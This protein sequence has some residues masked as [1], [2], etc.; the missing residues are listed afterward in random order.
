MP[1]TLAAKRHP[2]QEQGP[3]GIPCQRL[4]PP[5]SRQT[6]RKLKEHSDAF[7]AVL[8]PLHERGGRPLLAPGKAPAQGSSGAL[9]PL[10]GQFEPG[11]AAASQGLH[12]PVR[13]SP[14]DLDKRRTQSF[15][16]PRQVVSPGSRLV[17]KTRRKSFLKNSPFSSRMFGRGRRP[18]KHVAQVG[19]R[20]RQQVG[21]PRRGRDVRNLE[22]ELR[23]RERRMLGQAR[24]VFELRRCGQVGSRKTD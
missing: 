7:A 17:G 24:P 3:G 23:G 4:H 14:D 21:H 1:R 11:Q 2:G 22:V 16:R 18:Q 15:D 9:H 10:A 13:I 6:R 19:P 20:F 5:H 8:G 12:D